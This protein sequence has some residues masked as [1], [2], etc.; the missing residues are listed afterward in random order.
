ML[1]FA[2]SSFCMAVIASRMFQI[3]LRDFGDRD[4]IGGSTGS[5]GPRFQVHQDGNDLPFLVLSYLLP[6]TDRI[7]LTA[8]KP[9]ATDE[10]K[11]DQIN[12]VLL[13]MGTAWLEHELRR[14]TFG[15][16]SAGG[17]DAKYH[18]VTQVEVERLRDMLLAKECSY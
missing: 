10:I 11:N 2:T 13:R 16:S 7:V 4:D 17:V 5:A 14:G 8:P 12:V 6:K 9:V 15:A 18:L 3:R 1:L